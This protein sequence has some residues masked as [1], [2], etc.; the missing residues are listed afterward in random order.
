MDEALAG[1]ASFIEWSFTNDGFLTVTDN[2]RGISGRPASK[3]S[4]KIR[5]R[6]HHVHA[7]LRRANS[8]PRSTRLLC[9]LHGVGVSV[10]K[11]CP[12][13]SRSSRAQ[14]K[15]LPDEFRARPA[16][17]KLEDLARSTTAAGTRI[18]FKPDREFLRQG[19]LQAAA[20]VQDD[21]LKAY[22]F[23]GVEIAGAAIPALL[24]GLERCAP[25][26]VVHFPAG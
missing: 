18:R 21:A 12:R 16:K 11:R 24:K 17:G 13:G 14:P 23:G 5:A 20:A 15:T 7:A 10:V 22:L 25:R 3:I 19:R 6:S 26:T 1:H 8:I 4:E 9:G 2:G